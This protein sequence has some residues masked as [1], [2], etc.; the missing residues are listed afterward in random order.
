[1]TGA[2]FI[3]LAKAFDSIDH[4]ILL[5]KFSTGIA[6][7]DHEWFVDYLCG[8]MQIVDYQEIFSDPEAVITGVPR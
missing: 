5:K 4:C 8:R 3:D 7:R 6:G 2:V 1:M